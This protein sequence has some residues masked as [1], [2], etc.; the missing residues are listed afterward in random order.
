MGE[1]DTGSS[2]L[3][4]GDTMKK[5][6]LLTTIQCLFL[7]SFLSFAAVKINPVKIYEAGVKAYESG[8]YKKAIRL[9][10]SAIDAGLS[11]EKLK[12]SYRKLY[13][14]AFITDNPKKIGY[15]EA[16][17]ES[18]IPGFKAINKLA[19]TDLMETA[20]F[21]ASSL[22]HPAFR[23]RA[24]T[25][26]ATALRKA[27]KT[28]Q[29]A[30][31]FSEAIELVRSI[32]EDRYGFKA[33]TLIE[34]AGALVKGKIIWTGFNENQQLNCH[35]IPVLSITINF[36]NFSPGKLICSIKL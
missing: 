1:K 32:K 6:A 31:I 9:L 12:H 10:E 26:I 8:H 35:R 22:P 34:I 24:L 2:I 25:E 29:A 17:C 7:V 15:Y 16:K 27:G 3:I 30:H 28:E 4:Q 11:G 20:L 21:L 18:L 19:F 36:Y 33:R 14:S 5:I 23:A 13:F